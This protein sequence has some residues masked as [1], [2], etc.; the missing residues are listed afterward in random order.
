MDD[1]RRSISPPTEVLD[2]LDLLR[3]EALG[4]DATGEPAIWLSG[5]V[6]GR[7]GDSTEV[8]DAEGVVVARLHW[9]ADG[10]MTKP[11]WLGR[12]SPRPFDQFHAERARGWSGTL[13]VVDQA[14]VDLETAAAVATSPLRLLVLASTEDG[15][16]A[17]LAAVRAASRV[18]EQHPGSE[19]VV[20]PLGRR[21]AR[22]PEKR[23]RVVA[24]YGQGADV[25]D[26]GTMGPE[27]DGVGHATSDGLVIFF[28]GLSGSG[29]STLARAV[30]NRIVESSE[31]PVT[32]LDGDVV[33]RH[34]SE[35]LGFS[36]QDRDT[37]I[38]RIGWVAAEIARH[39]GLVICSPIAPF[40]RTRRDVRD[41]VEGA[42][43]RFLLVHVATPLEE[44]E[45]RDRKGLYARARI[46]E[47]PDFTGI[48]SPYEVPTD[49]DLVLDTTDQAVEP[50]R[51]LVLATAG[52]SLTTSRGS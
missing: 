28:T 42:G 7:P 35:G 22:R 43:G 10:V 44:C 26:L 32:L 1:P 27:A 33:R 47:I 38:R 46:G 25:V 9:D 29:K 39:G 3:S 12:R 45:R 52:L 21:A 6:V 41:M 40:A 5:T 16:P 23:A 13:V 30:R 31:R 17:E 19:L 11:T 18:H 14:T 34:L 37:N 15:D 50:L 48:S 4:A 2:D 24:S 36:V 8:T 49:A 51:D 20:V